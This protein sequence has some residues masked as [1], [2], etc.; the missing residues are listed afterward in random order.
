MNFYLEKMASQDLDEVKR[1]CDQ[2]HKQLR[3]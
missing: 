3:L 1:A 2:L